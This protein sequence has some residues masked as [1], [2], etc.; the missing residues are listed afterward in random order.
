MLKRAKIYALLSIIVASTAVGL[1]SSSPIAN[2]QTD[3]TSASGLYIQPDAQSELVA[4]IWRE[5]MMTCMRLGEG[6]GVTIRNDLADGNWFPAPGPVNGKS[7]WDSV[8]PWGKTEED[9]T[10]EGAPNVGYLIDSSDGKLWCNEGASGTYGAG[11]GFIKSFDSVYHLSSGNSSYMGAAC[12]LGFRPVDATE[13]SDSDCTSNAN[14]HSET[15]YSYP[16][17]DKARS[18]ID[19]KYSF[20]LFGQGPPTAE[21]LYILYAQTFISACH[22]SNAVTSIPDGKAG[23]YVMLQVVD[24]SGKITDTY[25]TVDVTDKIHVSVDESGG[26]EDKSCT[27]IAAA[28]NGSNATAYSEWLKKNPELAKVTGA[29]IT[30]SDTAPSTCQITGIGWMVCPVMNFLAGVAD[31]AY[32]ALDRLFLRLPPVNL[33]TSSEKNGTYRA[34]SIMRDLANIVFVIAFLIIVFSQV[35]SIGISNYGLKRL[36]PKLVM[37]AILVN[38]SYI[39]CAIAVDLSNIMGSSLKDLLDS[40]RVIPEGSV[41]DYNSG[42]GWAG[43]TEKIL[44]YSV[45]GGAALFGW[46]VLG[47]LGVALLAIVPVVLTVL[48]TMLIRQAAVVLLIVVSP[49]AFVALLL[50]NTEGYYKKWLG[51]FKTMLLMY[52]VVAILFGAAGLASD[53][54]MVAAK[55]SGNDGAQMLNGIVAGIVQILPLVLIPTV[56]K[57]SEGIFG[58]VTGFVNDNQKGWFDSKRNEQMERV[59]HSQAENAVQRASD[60]NRVRA[61]DRFSTLGS[62]RRQKR[63]KDRVSETEAL[64]ET[65]YLGTEQG[66]T[67]R[68]AAKNAQEAS[69]NAQ[70][71]AELTRIPSA[72]AQAIQDVKTSLDKQRK[73]AEDNSQAAALQSLNTLNPNALKEAKDAEARLHAAEN[74]TAETGTR[75]A[76]HALEAAEKESHINREAAETEAENHAT[77]HINTSASGQAALSRLEEA[78]TNKKS[79]DDISTAIGLDGVSGTALGNAVNAANT[80][81]AS[82][83]EASAI[84]TALADRT[85]A[86]QAE[87]SALR[88]ETADNNLARDSAPLV[89]DATRIAT[90][91][92]K[93]DREITEDLIASDVARGTDRALS[94]DRKD[95]ELIRKAEEDRLSAAS[96]GSTTARVDAANAGLEEKISESLA[97]AD[98]AAGTSRVL[99]N[100]A[101][102]AELIQKTEENNLS[103]ASQGDRATR[104]A[105]ARSDAM[106]KTAENLAQ[107]E[108][109]RDLSGSIDD[110]IRRESELDL[111]VAQS[112][113]DAD[114]AGQTLTDPALRALAEEQQ[115]NQAAASVAQGVKTRRFNRN[116]AAGAVD[117]E[118]PL[119]AAAGSPEVTK[120]VNATI[121]EAGEQE[122]RRE[123]QALKEFIARESARGVP[124]DDSLRT[125]AATTTDEYELMSIFN[126]IASRGRDNLIDE[127]RAAHPIGTDERAML[128][129][130]IQNNVSALVGKAPDQIKG[131]DAAFNAIKGDGMANLSAAATGRLINH[132]SSLKTRATRAGATADDINTYNNAL[133]AFKSAV[134]DIQRSADLQ[135]KFGRDMGDAITRLTSGT[136]TNIAG[137]ISAELAILSANDGK[138]R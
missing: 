97:A 60:P 38:V 4:K 11:N 69:Q 7:F 108:V 47:L 125:A 131:P 98:T 57:I 82:E 2:A 52:P 15:R 86:A 3:T 23:D 74:I 102:D 88:K 128:E 115:R 58:K 111:Q 107:A 10:K 62:I 39:L 70:T 45:V 124:A 16:S 9:L 117:I 12:T 46:S 8:V 90:A 83:N 61:F 109:T 129:Q 40:V 76:D 44:A 92:S 106:R 30:T 25:Y 19:S 24:A 50:P 79:A 123:Q 59:K 63:R 112:G 81:K 43:T 51:L 134:V 137:D 84:G 34:W 26:N 136:A 56:I 53:V 110:R 85:A 77:Q 118:S 87:E 35:T 68:N 5:A 18:V 17:R 33:D 127:Q 135:G 31:G 78:K 14:Q 95:A 28:A 42:A 99:S 121:T 65:A 100:D 89:S 96:Q 27:E 91:N 133:S 72:E 130:A 105:E 41:T 116:V 101:K 119:G 48:V 94:N 73:A 66:V 67:A 1:F 114:W 75:L 71:A 36:I 120:A 138:I 126:E 80:R 49:L 54:L 29:T 55:D 13:I 104:V 32:Y 103:A 20:K 132:L 113:S 64:G 6:D 22:P 93:L 37:A 122:V 21:Q